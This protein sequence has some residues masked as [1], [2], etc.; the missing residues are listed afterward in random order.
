M[1]RDDQGDSTPEDRS[2]GTGTVQILAPNYCR[3]V[4]WSGDEFSP[5][6]DPADG[7][8]SFAHAS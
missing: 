6:G 4:A 8:G 3:I 7:H 1:S 5:T 2:G